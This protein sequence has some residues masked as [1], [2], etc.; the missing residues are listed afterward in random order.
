MRFFT[1]IFSS[2]F[3]GECI[4]VHIQTKPDKKNN[5]FVPVPAFSS[6]RIRDHRPFSLMSFSQ[7]MDWGPG[8]LWDK[9]S[10]TL[11][12]L[13]HSSA[14]GNQSR[15]LNTTS[16]VTLGTAC[17]I[18]IIVTALELSQC[19]CLELRQGSESY[20]SPCPFNEAILVTPKAGKGRGRYPE[21]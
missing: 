7:A 18:V 8:L 15:Y 10:K 4:L 3:H 1:S 16:C 12:F 9:F 13:I 6:F 14:F 11:S 21:Y 19:S 20:C 2:T 5:T 17:E